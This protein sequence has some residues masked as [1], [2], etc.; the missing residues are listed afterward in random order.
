MGDFNAQVGKE[1]RIK[2]V[3]GKYTIHESINDNG[4]LMALFTNVS[5]TDF[6]KVSIKLLSIQTRRTVR[7]CVRYLKLYIQV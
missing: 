3:A 1:D 6:M 4:K 2:Q 7:K 5:V